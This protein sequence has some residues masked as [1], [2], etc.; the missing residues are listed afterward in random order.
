VTANVI[1][2]A[3]FVRAEEI[4]ACGARQA[5]RQEG[6]GEIERFI[7]ADQVVHPP[8]DPLGACKVVLE[9]VMVRHGRSPGSADAQD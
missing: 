2:R 3:F 9:G 7:A 4:Q 6:L 5:F 1:E 8:S